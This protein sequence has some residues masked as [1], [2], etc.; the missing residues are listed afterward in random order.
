MENVFTINLSS[1]ALERLF[2]DDPSAIVQIR[3]AAIIEFAKKKI[4]GVLDPSLRQE[5]EA[6][7]RTEIGQL[8]WNGTLLNPKIL[9]RIKEVCL[10]EVEDQKNKINTIIRET[11][12]SEIEKHIENL[13]EKINATVQAK[14]NAEIQ[15]HV[16]A[17]VKRKIQNAIK[18]ASE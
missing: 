13:H 2:T 4:T 6:L 16:A 7:V 17:E 10:E 12:V 11:V 3:K 15:N 8:A 5:I 14:L 9:A 18:A 1:K